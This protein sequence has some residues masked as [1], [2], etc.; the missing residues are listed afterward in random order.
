MTVFIKPLQGRHGVRIK[1][2]PS[3]Q[4]KLKADNRS[5]FFSLVCRRSILTNLRAVIGGLLCVLMAI[6]PNVPTTSAGGGRIMHLTGH[7]STFPGGVTQAIPPM[8]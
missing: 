3:I 6:R 8:A 5:L 2:Y 7:F 1:R 4:T